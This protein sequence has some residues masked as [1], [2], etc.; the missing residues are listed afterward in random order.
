MMFG[1]VCGSKRNPSPELIVGNRF[2]S[3]QRE[4]EGRSADLTARFPGY[5][6]DSILH[7]SQSIMNIIGG[8]EAA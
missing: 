8:P 6:G 7:R 3:P 4:N 1:E 2:R 5:R